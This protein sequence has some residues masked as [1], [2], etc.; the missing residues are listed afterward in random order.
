MA[1]H[2]ARPHDLRRE[3]RVVDGIGE[4]LR[5]EAQ[6]GV[7]PVHA[8]ALA[9]D[10]SEPV[11]GVE[12]HPGLVRPQLHGPPR[13]AVPDA[14]HRPQRR[15][16]GAVHGVVGVVARDAAS[17]TARPQ[18]RQ[19]RPHGRR[20]AEVV[21]RAGHGRQRARRHERGVHRR[22]PRREELHRF[23]EDGPAAVAAE[24]PVRVVREVHRGG[25]APRR[26][27]HAHAQH[28]R[29]RQTVRHV[30]VQVAGEPCFIVGWLRFSK[31]TIA[32]YGI[33]RAS[34]AK[35]SQH[36]VPCSPSK[37]W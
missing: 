29:A 20:R 5:L 4:P 33:G 15:R 13:G 32:K 14:R 19:A 27:V 25:P 36:T 35:P 17:A 6:R 7:P 16:R 1:I 34:Q 11:A 12:L 30:H 37:L 26:G 18:V 10:A 3:A 21:G 8:T 22:V 9:P 24:V 28:V 31:Q 2:L 23:A